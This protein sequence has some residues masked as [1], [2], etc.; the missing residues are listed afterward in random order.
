MATKTWACHP[1][2]VPD[3][4]QDPIRR[5][6]PGVAGTVAFPGNPLDINTVQPFNGS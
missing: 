1:K 4:T 5:P 6:P 3:R 2:T